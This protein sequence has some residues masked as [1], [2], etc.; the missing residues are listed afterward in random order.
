MP[1]LVK[2]AEP[3]MADLSLDKAWYEAAVVIPRRVHQE[4]FRQ[5]CF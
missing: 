2:L 5:V 4:D 3:T 1:L